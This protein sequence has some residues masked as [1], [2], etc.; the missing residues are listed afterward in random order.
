MGVLGRIPAF[1]AILVT[2]GVGGVAQPPDESSDHL[3]KPTGAFGVGR[4]TLLCEDSSRIEPLDSNATPRRIMVDVWYPAE[5]SASQEAV[6]AE[7]LNA[8]E[9]ERGLGAERLKKELGGSYDLI[10][11]G[12]VTTHA[13]VRAPFANSLRLAPLLLFSPG[14]GM[15][16]ELYTAQMEELASHGY[17]VAAMNHSYDGFLTV[18]PDGSYVEH[19]GRRWPKIPSFEGEANLN[20]LEWHTA[21]ILAV[22]NY[23]SRL[24]GAPSPQLPFA[25]RVDVTRAGAFGHS[26][27]GVAAAHACQRDQRIKACLNQDGAM[28]MKPF[29]LDAQGWGMNQAFMLIERPPNHEPLTDSDLS[30]MKMTRS[31]AMEFIAR[32]NADRD[33]ALRST[34]TGSYR[35]LLRRNVTTHMDFSDLMVLSAKNDIELEQR[36]RVLALVRSYTLA[37]FDRYVRGMKAPLLDRSTPDQVLESVEKFS[38]A[39]RPN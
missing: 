32:L 20:Q 29:Y 30:A 31:R 38:P 27:G 12:R 6:A 15:I 22:L 34:G 7:Y 17:V 2:V 39:S 19:D 1:V 3:P 9:F 5:R 25:G 26:F 18:F 4:L 14:G 36:M 21:D 35:V 24:N 33:R 23:L 11:T 37:F 10:K 8:A 16:R 13:V 28:G